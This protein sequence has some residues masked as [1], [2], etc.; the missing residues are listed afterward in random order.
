MNIKLFIFS[1]LAVILSYSGLT[2]QATLR[3]TIADQA[4]TYSLD[5]EVSYSVTFSNT[6]NLVEVPAAVESAGVVVNQPAIDAA[7]ATN[8]AN[9][10]SNISSPP[11]SEIVNLVGTDVYGQAIIVP[12]NLNAPSSFNLAPE[13]EV[14]FQGSVTIPSDA[15]LHTSNSAGHSIQIDILYDTDGVVD[16]PQLSSNLA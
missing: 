10:A 11:L 7:N 16:V 5:D 9:I 3:I 4:G 6:T 13:E 14:T 8:V 12:A 2:A 1:A 15:T